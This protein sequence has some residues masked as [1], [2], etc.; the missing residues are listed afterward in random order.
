MHLKL[1]LSHLYMFVDLLDIITTKVHDDEDLLLGKLKKEG[2]SFLP[3]VTT[4]AGLAFFFCPLAH[5]RLCMWE[6]ASSVEEPSRA[7]AA[8][9]EP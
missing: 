6:Q 9:A 1:E 7:E 4:F 5:P 3:E 8:E 2:L